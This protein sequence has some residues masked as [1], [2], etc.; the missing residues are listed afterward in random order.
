MRKVGERNVET[1]T[2]ALDSPYRKYQADKIDWRQFP[3]CFKHQIQGFLKDSPDPILS[4]WRTKHSNVWDMEK[5]RKV[6]YCFNTE[7][8]YNENWQALKNLTDNDYKVKVA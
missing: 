6:N 4:N 8:I 7:K 3:H 1:S 5:D 2:E